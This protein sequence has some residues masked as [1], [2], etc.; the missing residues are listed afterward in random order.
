VS[1]AVPTSADLVIIG[2][3][4]IG[5]SLALE[6]TR[7]GRD[8]TILDRG[9]LGAAST[10]LNAGGVRRQFYQD[11]NVLAAGVTI[12]QL[13]SWQYD[14]GVDLGYRQV[15]Y[16]LMYATEGQRARLAEGVERQNALGIASRFIGLDEITELA[17]E[18]QTEGILGAC[19]GPE[20]GYFDP[21]SLAGHLRS[22]VVDAGVTVCEDTAVTGVTQ[23]GGRITALQTTGGTIAPGTVVNAAGAW[24]PSLA[25]HWGEELPIIPRRSQVF[26]FENAPAMGEQMPHSF[27]TEA[28]FYLRA[29][30]T[31]L[32]SGAAF[33]P[34]L[35]EAPPTQD[36]E[37]DWSEAQEL[38]RRI[39]VRFPVLAGRTFDRAWAG[40]IE[41]TADDNPIIGQ[42]AAENVYT[43]AGF[44]GHGMCVGIGLSSSIAA[45]INGRDP[46][47]A[48]DIYRIDR[49][50]GDG[51]S[52][53]EGLWLRERP[54]R[55]EEWLA[56]MPDT[57]AVAA[58]GR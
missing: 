56:P 39:G 7:T 54:S 41:V 34:I 58:S 45:E 46:E 12:A 40:V 43:A 23:Q 47:I 5:M 24:A 11:A 18:V 29:H 13:Q 1:T 33:K 31:E 26:V 6:L 15:G 8:V 53:T 52:R 44:S 19:F 14:D 38:A 49:F 25:R 10:S 48:L 17:P 36:L 32:W 51:P 21:P 50:A 22:L 28:R 4:I 3:G 57:G 42:A 30:G 55:I 35:D 2:G 27:D 16:M 20:D 9:R 37:A